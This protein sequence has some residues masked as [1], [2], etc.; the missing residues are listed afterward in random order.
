MTDQQAAISRIGEALARTRI[1]LSSEKA[2]QAAIAEM[3]AGA[4]LAAERE[5]ILAPGERP[6]FF[7]P[8]SGLAIEVKIR[9]PKMAI[10][11]QLRRYAAHDRVRG[12]LL[13]SNTAMGLPAEIDGK[14]ACILSLGRAWL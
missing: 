13:L 3:L 14:P 2:A 1:D 12:L 7:L 10:F 4:G 11:R 8:E 5:F 6:D 9:A